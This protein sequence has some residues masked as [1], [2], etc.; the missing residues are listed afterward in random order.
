MRATQLT[1]PG[2]LLQ[3]YVQPPATRSGA[4]WT[5]KAAFRTPRHFHGQL[6]FLVVKRGTLTE[7]IGGLVQT[8]HAGQ[9]IWHLPALEHEMLAASRDLDMR[10]VQLEPALGA[11]LENAPLGSAARARRS[12]DKSTTTSGTPAFSWWFWEL[13]CRV[14]GRPVI[15]LSRRDFAALL[16]DCERTFDDEWPLG[17]ESPRL[18]R[19]LASAWRATQR[20]YTDTRPSSLVELA[21]CLLLQAANLK[22]T[23]VC[24]ILDVSPGYLSRSFSRDLDLGFSELRSRIRIASF[25]ALVAG[26]KPSLLGAALAAGFGSYS[27]FHRMF[28]QVVGQTPKEY[29]R[30]GGRRRRAELTALNVDMLH[31]SFVDLGAFA[32]AADE[33]RISPAAVNTR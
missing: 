29:L 7:R 3:E 19:L 30:L 5:Y 27:Q 12:L 32:C 2:A 16:E 6:E 8:A 28:Q 9:L 1:R 4:I 24:R 10:V 33:A 25:L 20:D 14:A 21:C 17:D 18:C 22:R 23:D 15:E 13:G 11:H 31:S 26:D